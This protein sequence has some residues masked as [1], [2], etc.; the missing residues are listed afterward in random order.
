[1]AGRRFNAKSSKLKI[2]GTW[3]DG[4]NTANVNFAFSGPPGSPPFGPGSLPNSTVYSGWCPAFASDELIAYHP[5][6]GNVLMCD[7]SVHFVSQ[8]VEPSILWRSAR[9]KA[10]RRST[11]RGPTS[12]LP[13]RPTVRFSSAIPS[14]ATRTHPRWQ[15]NRTAAPVRVRVHHDP[16]RNGSPG[17]RL[18]RGTLL[19][20]LETRLVLAAFTPGDIAVVRVGDGS[21]LLTN[22]STAV[23]IDEYDPS[24]NSLVQ[25]IALPT[26]DSAPQHALTMSGSASSEGAEPVDQRPVPAIGRLRHRARIG[27]GFG[28]G[29]DH[30]C[31][32]RG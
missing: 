31:S 28:H 18:R 7:G 5:N 4:Y 12:D 23:F 22:A 19:E 8:Q 26:A 24:T 29:F 27:R 3:A 32:D 30:R 9:A 11:I 14:P 10:A 20:Q 2:S 13:D 1:M 25:S 21:G 17:S 6:G 16:P 15:R